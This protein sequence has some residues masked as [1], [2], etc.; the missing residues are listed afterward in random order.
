MACWESDQFI[1]HWAMLRL[2]FALPWKQGN[3]CGGK[4][5]VEEAFL[6]NSESI[7]ESGTRIDN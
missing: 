5:L 1:G 2:R 4:G 6:Q 3:S 7:Q